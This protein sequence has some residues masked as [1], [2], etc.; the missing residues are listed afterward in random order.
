[1]KSKIITTTIIILTTCI[2]LSGFISDYNSPLV[3][4]NKKLTTCKIK[5]ST[6]GSTLKYK[7]LIDSTPMPIDYKNVSVTWRFRYTH[8]VITQVL[9][10]F[11]IWSKGTF[12]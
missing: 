6:P 9:D 1:M 7:N 11:N 8:K 4:F 10:K 3:V 5:L 2:L 12:F